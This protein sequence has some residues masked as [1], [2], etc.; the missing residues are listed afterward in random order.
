MAIATEPAGQRQHVVTEPAAQGRDVGSQV[1]RLHFGLP[2][3]AQ[4]RGQLATIAAIPGS[5]HLELEGL[6]SRREA[7]GQACEH[8]GHRLALL[9][10]VEHVTVEEP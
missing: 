3:P 6:A 9:A 2:G 4:A 8:I 10:N 1:A 5:A 7:L